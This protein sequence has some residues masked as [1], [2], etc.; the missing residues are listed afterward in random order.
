MSDRT[1]MEAS[2]A[3]LWQ[4]LKIR[5]A[6]RTSAPLLQHFAKGPMLSRWGVGSRKERFSLL[7][8]RAQGERLPTP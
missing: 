3:D 1:G 8:K 2:A 6:L 4:G 7:P 5:M